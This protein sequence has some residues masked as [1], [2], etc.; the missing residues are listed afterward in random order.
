MMESI[1]VFFREFTDFQNREA[2]GQG[3]TNHDIYE[4]RLT[5]P[6][7]S[8]WPDHRLTPYSMYFYYVRINKDGRL[9]IDH[10]FYATGGKDHP[11]NWTMIPH[12]EEGLRNLVKA[13]A[14][15]AR[16]RVR[17]EDKDPPR[18]ATG[19]FNKAKWRTKSYVAI[20][21]DEAHWTLRKKGP[22]SGESA[23]TFIVKEGNKVGTPNHSFFDA[24]D[25]AINMPIG[26]GPE[27]DTRSAIV[28][29][30]HMK[31]DEAGRDLGEDE[32]QPFEFKIFLDV[33]MQ[34]PDEPATIVIIDPGGTNGGPSV[35]PP[36][37]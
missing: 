25:L 29:V 32:D 27:E 10:Y 17:P 28:F 16:P 5:E 37:E 11:E 15:N 22:G 9:V 20:F 7:T 3:L 6:D 18:A 23:V 33:R 14:L 12:E 8:L 30:N 19:N 13:L 26:D 36:P 2:D 21:F 31:A 35:P 1:D 34:A 24:I 4:K